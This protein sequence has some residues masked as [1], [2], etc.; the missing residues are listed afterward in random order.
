MIVTQTPLRISFLGGNTDL[1]AYFK[2]HGGSILTTAIDKYIYCTVNKR[3]DDE[4]WINYSEKERVKDVKDIKHDIVREALK[5][6]DITRGIEISFLSDIPSEG[7]GLGSSSSVA[8]GLLNA[9]A[10]YIGSPLTNAELASLAC[11]IEI[12]AL[13]KPIGVQDQ[14]IA[15]YGGLRNII[16]G[17]ST[18]VLRLEIPESTITDFNNSLMLFYTNR[19]R[20]AGK[21][22]EGTKPDKKIL[23]KQKELANQ[24]VTCL[25]LA[26]VEG[27]GRLM[28]KYWELKKRLNSKV[29]DAEINTMYSKARKAGATGG[30]ILGAGGGGFMLLQVPQEE[31]EAVRK[32]LVGYKE[33]QFRFEYFGSRV[34]FNNG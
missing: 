16:L 31:K 9:L 7:S 33:L 15:S 13:K 14:I 2:E 3:F 23:D 27:V 11:R 5:L 30:K 29:A 4:I 22:L 21:V 18:Q 17:Q 26:D 25:K 10:Q 1:P 32:A 8:V 12:D 6:M 20:K 28:H 24:G 34:I 19:T